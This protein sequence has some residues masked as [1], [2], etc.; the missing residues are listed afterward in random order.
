MEKLIITAALTGGGTVPTQSPH[1]PITPEEIAQEARRA[2][3]AGA[4]IVHIHP[5]D[6]K[7]G[8]P[9]SDLDV[10]KE[11]YSRISSLTDVIIC[12]STGVSRFLT[13][14]QRVAIVPLVEPE[15]ASISLGTVIGTRESILK[16]YR[17]K[18]YKFAWE[19]D[20]LQKYSSGLFANTVKDIEFFYETILS[21]NAKPEIEIFDIGWLGVL[22][23]LLKSKGRYPPPIWI[24]FVLGAFGEY[25]ARV[26]YFPFIKQIADN[27]LGRENYRYSVIGIGYPQQ[28]YLATMAIM[29]GGHV[30]VG[31]EDNLLIN[32][33][34]LAKSNA[35]QVEKVVRLAKELGREVATPEEARRILNLKGKDKVKY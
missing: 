22:E 23:Y 12:V 10:Y 7:E 19:K 4:A 21:A 1:I 2:A 25:P 28:F 11:I 16:R 29:M 34:I 20:F 30:R 9:T 5:R 33:G 13:P 24:Q 14:E 27:M 15:L 17:D 3:E 31:L 18:D 8:F 32:K 35:E 6:P 26:D